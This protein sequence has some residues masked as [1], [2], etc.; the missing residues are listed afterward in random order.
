MIN[1][2]SKTSEEPNL[3]GNKEQLIV[4]IRAKNR[5][6]RNLVSYIYLKRASLPHH[7]LRMM[8]VLRCPTTQE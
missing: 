6:I 8:K 7:T 4:L 3:D 1:N 2:D 5:S